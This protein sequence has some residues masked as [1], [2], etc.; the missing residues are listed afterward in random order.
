MDREYEHSTGGQ[1]KDVPQQW[2]DVGSWTVAEVDATIKF[3]LHG[4][5]AL[6]SNYPIYGWGIQTTPSMDGVI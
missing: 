1:L 2:R 6:D 5:Y 3:C 4:T